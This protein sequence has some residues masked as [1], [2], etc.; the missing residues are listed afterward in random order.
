MGVIFQQTVVWKWNKWIKIQGLRLFGWLLNQK[1]TIS[2][3]LCN[4]I[5]IFFLAGTFFLYAGIA[6]L[7]FIFLFTLLPETKDRPLEEIIDLF[8]RPVCSCCGDPNAPYDI[9]SDSEL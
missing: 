8:A 9:N 7:G 2:N 5:S 4:P 1:D 6:V 3:K